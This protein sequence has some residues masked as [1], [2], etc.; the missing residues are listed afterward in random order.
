MN[1]R[2]A[3]GPAPARSLG[4]LVASGPCRRIG[5][6]GFDEAE[7]S[8]IVGVTRPEHARSRH[9]LERLGMRYERDVD[10]FGIHA[11]LYAVIRDDPRAPRSAFAF[12][13]CRE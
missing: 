2:A 10:V 9:V 12:R 6:Y 8:R 3:A 11:V 13:S 1:A 7:L 5:D 4:F